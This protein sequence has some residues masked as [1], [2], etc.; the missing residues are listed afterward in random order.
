MSD[1]YKLCILYVSHL[2]NHSFHW[3]CMCSFLQPPLTIIVP[4]L[5]PLAPTYSV[6]LVQILVTEEGSRCVV[7]N[8]PFIW[9]YFLYLFERNITRYYA[10]CPNFFTQF[11]F[12][13]NLLLVYTWNK[14]H[15]QIF[16]WW[17]KSSVKK[18][19]FLD[20]S[21]GDPMEQSQ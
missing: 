11:Y 13:Q 15:H 18:Q 9:V 12:K 8:P 4:N 19:K 2:Q 5:F 6:F 7:R 20:K 3:H 1:R 16:L 17:C 21:K 10:K 14:N